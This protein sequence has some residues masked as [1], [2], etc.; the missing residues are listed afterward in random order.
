MMGRSE[1]ETL[2]RRLEEQG[3]RLV[4]EG[5]ALRVSAPKGVLDEPLRAQLSANKPLLI[6]LLGERIPG[7][8]KRTPRDGR[9]PMSAAQQRQ[10]R[11]R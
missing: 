9:L 10:N 5:D 2:L 4:L 8:L 6:S 3:V 1:V 7:A 11:R